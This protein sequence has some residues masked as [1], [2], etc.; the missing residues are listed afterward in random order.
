[1][2]EL[3][4]AETK[5]PYQ[6]HVDHHGKTYAEVEPD[7]DYFLRVSS[8]DPRRVAVK[9]VV[10]GND[11]GYKSA[12]HQ[13]GGAQTRGLLHTENGISHHTAL[14]FNS[15]FSSQKTAAAASSD[16]S[17]G[18]WTGC[19]E[20][21][22][23]ERIPVEGTPR[24]TTKRDF[25]SK[26]NPNTEHVLEGLTVSSNKKSV[27]SKEGT[28]ITT[29]EVSSGVR[30]KY[31]LGL[32][33]ASVELKYCSTVGLIEAKILPPPPAPD[34]SQIRGTINDNGDDD[35]EEKPRAKKRRGN[36]NVMVETCSV[37]SS[38]TLQVAPDVIIVENNEDEDVKERSSKKRRSDE[39]VK[40]ETCTVVRSQTLDVVDLTGDD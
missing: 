28:A 11:L 22:I 21:K 23:Y 13:Y 39:N 34:V 32:K 7:T 36:E 25:S 9:F 33:L 37:F 8:Y 29:K 40:V 15:L 30:T 38:Q 35:I 4:D 19:V 26:W 17:E 2:L 27:N 14:R 3:I 10:D 20:M 12:L 6:E 16:P 31:K 5:A 24:S 1:M 18:H